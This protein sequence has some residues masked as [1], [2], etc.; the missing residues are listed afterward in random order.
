MHSKIADFHGFRGGACPVNNVTSTLELHLT[1]FYQNDTNGALTLFVV[2][3][4][5]GPTCITVISTLTTFTETTENECM[6][7]PKD[8]YHLYFGQN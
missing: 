7:L 4:F 1:S 6:T 2:Y 8:T 5:S 3:V